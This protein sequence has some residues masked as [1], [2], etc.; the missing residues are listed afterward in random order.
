[1]GDCDSLGYV[2]IFNAIP[3]PAF[4]VDGD[5]R[6]HNLNP[7]ASAM[8]GPLK[9]IYQQRGG[10]ALHCLH[11][12]DVPE[13]C[14]HG[15]ACKSC[16]IRDSVGNCLKGVTT[17]RRRM[18]FEVKREL[19]VVES[20]L[21]IS[22]SPLRAAGSEI[23]LV[24]IEDITEFTKLRAMIPICARCK[25]VHNDA[26]YWQLVEEYFHDYIGVEFTHGLCPECL[27]ECYGVLPQAP[28]SERL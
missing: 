27:K 28:P 14:G 8:F 4:L 25:R 1:M 2:D 17:T 16:V 15:P 13:G 10:E 3:S 7:A 20:E 12:H 22:A 19:K 21:L 24:I 9:A 18:K 11:A 6:I 23:A 5:V 26:Q